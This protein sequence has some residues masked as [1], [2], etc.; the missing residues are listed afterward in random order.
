[1]AFRKQP[2]QW[3]KGWLITLRLIQLIS[4]VV[5][6]GITGFFTY[7][8]MREDLGIPRELVVLDV[9][10][11]ITMLNVLVSFILLCCRSLPTMLVLIPDI[12]ISILWAFVFGY[13]AR[14]LGSTTV[15][16]CS[17]ENFGDYTVVCHLYK[18][19]LAFSALGW[20]MHVASFWLA[21][22]VRR[23]SRHEYTPAGDGAGIGLMGMGGNSGYKPVGGGGS[24]A[25][26]VS[27][28]YK[29]EAGGSSYSSGGM[30]TNLFLG[31]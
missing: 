20:I 6:V 11:S 31:L 25:G 9:I 21:Y 23:K 27:T 4:A 30:G 19:L 1:M 18:V 22:S 12:L 15:T 13:L 17:S 26:K 7:H 3:P 8:L 14:A 24:E 29:P 5:V 16:E 28:A 10:G 2:P